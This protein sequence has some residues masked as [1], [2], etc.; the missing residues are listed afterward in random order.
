MSASAERPSRSG[1]SRTASNDVRVEVPVVHRLH[2]EPQTAP[3]ACIDARRRRTR[4]CSGSSDGP[5]D[6]ESK[7]KLIGVTPDRRSGSRPSRAQFHMSQRLAQRTT[8]RRAAGSGPDS[9]CSCSGGSVTLSHAQLQK[10]TV[11]TRTWICAR[12]SSGRTEPGRRPPTLGSCRPPRTLSIGSW[13]RTPIEAHTSRLPVSLNT[14]V[15]LERPAVDF[16][17][18]IRAFLVPVL[19]GSLERE[20]IHEGGQHGRALVPLPVHPRNGRR[21]V[22]QFQS[23]GQDLV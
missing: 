12:T 13:P 4:S 20:A 7:R 19:V 15:V 11:T 2:L 16:S 22:I 3:P 1:R 23:E 14:P 8:G 6:S 21:L 18:L 10:R 9:I 17:G 5:P